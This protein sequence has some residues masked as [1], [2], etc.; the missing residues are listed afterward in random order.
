MSDIANFIQLMNTDSNTDNTNNNT[1]IHIP[2]INTV[3]KI[4][5][6]NEK[7]T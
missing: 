1:M 7:S 3:Y 4:F 2:S 5:N 6:L